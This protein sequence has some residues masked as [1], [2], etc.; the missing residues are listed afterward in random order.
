M[1]VYHACEDHSNSSFAAPF[2]YSHKLGEARG[3]FDEHL[4]KGFTEVIG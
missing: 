3:L 1:K 2:T 4:I